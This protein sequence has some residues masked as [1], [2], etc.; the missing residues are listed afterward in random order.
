MEFS[1][2]SYILSFLEDV[3]EDYSVIYVNCYPSF[4]GNLF[5]FWML[6]GTV[7]L[8]F[9]GFSLIT[10][11][12]ISFYL[13]CLKFVW[14]RILLFSFYNSF[15]VMPANF[16]LL[17]LNIP[18][19]SLLQTHGSSTCMEPGYCSSRF[20]VYELFY[21]VISFQCLRVQI[22]VFGIYE[23][24]RD[25]NFQKTMISLPFHFLVFLE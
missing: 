25:H 23:I 18:P 19:F 13:S 12:Q 15:I 14:L 20:H 22:L 9:A 2:D 10:W 1:L 8:L 7:F 3:F 5:L 24:C 11:V 17:I 6:L 16:S 21:R 4:V